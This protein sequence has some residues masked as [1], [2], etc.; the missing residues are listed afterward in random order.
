[1]LA[2]KCPQCGGNLFVTWDGGYK[3]ECLQCSR[4]APVPDY[5]LEKLPT[6]HRHYDA[7]QVERS[8][9]AMCKVM[10]WKVIPSFSRQVLF[11]PRN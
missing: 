8:S 5:V 11:L 7:D 9:P 2:G 3:A 1:M 4:P 6:N 10:A